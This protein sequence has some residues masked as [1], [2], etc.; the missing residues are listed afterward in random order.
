MRLAMVLAAPLLL[1]LAACGD[2]TPQKSAATSAPIRM[3]CRTK[4]EAGLKAKDV[5]RKLVE[6]KKDGRLT[7]EQYVAFN[8]TMSDGL[9]AWAETENLVAY[10][11]TLQRVVADAGLS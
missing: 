7:P 1:C 10:C 5:T 11:A 3:A 9:R 2:N 6:A 4:E 8:N